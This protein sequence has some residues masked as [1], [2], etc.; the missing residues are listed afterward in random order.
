M[1]ALVTGGTGCVG[2]ALVERLLANGFE[3]R[4][5]V[6]K[7][8]DLHHLKTTGAQIVFGDVTDYESLKVAVDGVDIVFHAAAKVTPGWGTW[9]EFEKTTVKGT[10]NLLKAAV[11]GGATRFLQVSSYTVYGEACLKGDIPADE[12]TECAVCLTPKTYYDYAKL[13][14][15]R[16]CWE[17]HKLGKIKVS[18]IRIGSVYGPRDRLI[19]D[20]IYRYAAS[21]IIL[22][23]G[24]GNPRYAIVNSYDVADLAILAATS[25]RGIGEVYN[26][27][28]AEPTRLKQ[29]AQAMVRARGGRRIWGT[30]PFHV[31]YVWCY[32]M[33]LVSTLR[34]AKTMPFLN[35]YFIL[36]L[37]MECN[38]DA[39][40]AKR[41]LG[42]VPK[43]SLEE[44]TRQYVA[45]RHAEEEAEKAKKARHPAK[46]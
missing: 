27:A 23:P 26:V 5:L 38:L 14:A 6:R 3:V 22:W 2:S 33:E 28:C 24:R 34:R 25:E 16:A 7:T 46:A 29:F 20:R 30:I 21:P 35:R 41:E 43:V 19:S 42:W 32:L 8:S 44:G 13:L 40:K 9:E 12:S 17:Y 31:A 37:N 36:Q 18:M 15:E 1:K 39:S 11:A 45:W 10:E 4:A